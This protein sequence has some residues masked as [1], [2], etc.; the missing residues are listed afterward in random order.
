MKVAI[1][2][3]GAVGRGIAQLFGDAV[4]FDEPKGIGTRASVN[5]CDARKIGFAAGFHAFVAGNPAPMEPR[6]PASEEIL[7]ATDAFI[8]ALQAIPLQRRVVLLQRRQDSLHRGKIACVRSDRS[9]NER[10]TPNI[11]ECDAPEP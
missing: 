11:P 8:P 4:L 1:I 9:Q 2:G 7:T 10:V 6:T 3:A 5:A